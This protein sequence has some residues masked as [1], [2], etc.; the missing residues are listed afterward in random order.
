[1]SH[2]QPSA[3]NK[4]AAFEKWLYDKMGL[5]A[6][7][8]PERNCYKEFPAHIVWK[9]WQARGAEKVLPATDVDFADD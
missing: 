5:Q 3:T 8:E 7:W 6:E 4:R 2:D 9:A 1:M